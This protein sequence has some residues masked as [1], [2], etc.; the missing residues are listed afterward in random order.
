M[1]LCDIE[2]RFDI[3][4]TRGTAR[5]EL[6]LPDRSRCRMISHDRTA[7]QSHEYLCCNDFFGQGSTLQTC[8]KTL[9]TAAKTGVNCELL[10]GDLC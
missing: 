3:D 6:A 1:R 9:L 7:D 2:V 8:D 4:A 5:R 10:N